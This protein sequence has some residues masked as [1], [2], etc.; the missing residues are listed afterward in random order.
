MKV[1]EQQ[2]ISGIKKALIKEIKKVDAERPL[3][4]AMIEQELYKFHPGRNL[5][6]EVQMTLEKVMR[7]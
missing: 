2:Y 1:Y 6:H 3:S 7:C 4:D 5:G